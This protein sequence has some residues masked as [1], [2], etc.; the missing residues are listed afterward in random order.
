MKLT[1]RKEKMTVQIMLGT[2]LVLGVIPPL[3]MF[4]VTRRKNGYYREASRKALNF[5]LTIFPF[6]LSSS[7]LPQ[8][9]KYTFLMIETFIILYAMFCIALQKP[10][11]YPAIPY[12]KNKEIHRNE[13]LKC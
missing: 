7:F 12:I 3:V 9:F 5:H 13:A 8:W 2:S 6:F 10:Y 1:T 11:H 4:M